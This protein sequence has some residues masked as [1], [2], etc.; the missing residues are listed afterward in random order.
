[1]ITFDGN[2]SKQRKWFAEKQ[3]RNIKAIDVPAKT[4]KWDGFTFKS[5][6]QG[7]LSGGRVTAPMGAVVLCSNN[8][9][10]LPS[11]NSV[12][13]SIA[14]YWA[15]GFVSLSNMYAMSMN[16]V[17]SGKTTIA[18]ING[19]TEDEFEDAGYSTVKFSPAR[20]QFYSGIDIDGTYENASVSNAYA[21]LP[22][23][24]PY[25]GAEGFRI[26]LNDVMY[27][28]DDDSDTIANDLQQIIDNSLTY[29]LANG[30]SEA[31]RKTMTLQY[32]SDTRHEGRI[33]QQLN[34]TYQMIYNSGLGFSES[35]KVFCAVK[36]SADAFEYIYLEDMLPESD[37]PTEV[38]ESFLNDDGATPLGSYAFMLDDVQTFLHA[39]WWNDY[40]SEY[41]DWFAVI[42]IK[43]GS[44][45]YVFNASDF[46]S[47]FD[48]LSSTDLVSSGGTYDRD[49]I[50][51]MLWIFLPYP[52][53][54]NVSPYDSV[55]FHAHNSKVYTWTRKY[56]TIEFSTTGLSSA[57]LI[58]P[59]DITDNEGC[60]P[61][62]TYS[63]TFNES[64]LYLCS[65]NQ[66]K[67]QIRSVHYGSPF[68]GWTELPGIDDG[69]TLFHVRP[70]E[71]SDSYI[72]LIGVIKATVDDVESY[73]FASLT[74]SA[75][76]TEHANWK[77]M[78]KL[79]FSVG[80]SDNFQVGLYGD[81][82]RVNSLS[83]YL[84]PPAS[85]GQLPVGEYS[86]YSIG[87]P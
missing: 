7:D 39:F 85:V 79:P 29:Y 63:G 37:I 67:E 71:V 43:V 20:Y 2:R 31:S 76:D 64:P 18:I 38:R 46:T 47:L 77:R 69:D 54:N 87:L 26:T 52:N 49:S 61:D 57:T 81:D 14:E 70:V 59:D 21:G 27:I 36:W 35:D 78:G 82:S 17:G 84:S 19:L 3:I 22:G 33:V 60:R 66:V 34:D 73:Y 42:S 74:W 4:V 45:A 44:T 72:F 23:V 12:K 53:I 28:D 41:P 15:G 24:M 50:I 62:I 32:R 25:S 56:G 55:M 65:C 6:Q 83:Q 1:M 68:T 8:E 40:D 48:S 58:L 75:E 5:W 30:S 9:Y 51:R 10:A 80:S 16:S 13:I 86:T 11:S